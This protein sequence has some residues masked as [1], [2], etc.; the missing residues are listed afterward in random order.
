MNQKRNT[1]QKAAVFEALNDAKGFISAQAL[2]QHLLSEGNKLGLTTVYRALT[3]L[4]ESNEAD[5]LQ[6][7]DGETKYRIC[8]ESHHHHLICT[9]CGVAVE[10][11][12]PGFENETNALA[13]AHGFSQVSHSIE[14]FGLCEKCGVAS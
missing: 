9:E 10:F 8:G 14:L 11:D 13:K 6:G 12:L 2:H 3:D 1:W 7:A 4:V 5:A